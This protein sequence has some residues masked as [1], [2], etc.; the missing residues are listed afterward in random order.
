MKFFHGLAN[1]LPASLMLWGAIF[2][3]GELV[4]RSLPE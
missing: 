4:A 2:W 1:A 3:L